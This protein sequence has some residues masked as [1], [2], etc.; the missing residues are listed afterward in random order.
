MQKILFILVIT[1]TL[2]FATDWTNWKGPN[3]NLT[4]DESDWDAMSISDPDILWEANLGKGH[5]AFAITEEYLFTTGNHQ[6]ITANVGSFQVGQ[7]PGMKQDTLY[8]DVVYCLDAE[9]GEEIWTYSYPCKHRDWP[10][11]RTTPVLDG[12]L[13][14]ILSWEGHL[15]CFDANSGDVI[16]KKHLVNDGLSQ[17]NSWGFAGSPVVDGEMLLLTANK[18]GVALNKKTGNVIW[19]S[20][21]GICGLTTPIIF[22]YNGKKAAV[23]PEEKIMH[24]VDILNGDILLSHDYKTCNDPV[25]FDNKIY[26]S[27]EH[28]RG[29]STMYEFSGDT[30]KMV[31]QNN[32]I[33]KGWAFMNHAI[34]DGFTYAIGHYKGKHHLHCVELATGELKW[35]QRVGD[36]W[37]SNIIAGDKLIILNGEGKLIIAETNP[38]AYTEIA[39][40]QIL[41]MADN[42]GVQE[43]WQCACWTMPVLSNGKLYVRDNYGKTV[44]LNVE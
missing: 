19:K 35:V 23:I 16:W 27:A 8:E 41:E 14:F 31:W 15:F 42:T 44:C 2:I 28:N 33:I 30:L 9:T 24:I 26:F 22:D 13:L 36:R 10:G 37:G 3:G 6:V 29:H 38:E 7:T 17:E 12:D 11:P 5:A 43:P 4:T 1:T 20:E 34:K 25:I 21:P 40:T 32:K 39:S 18:N